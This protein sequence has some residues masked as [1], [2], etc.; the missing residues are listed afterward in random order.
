MKKTSRQD[1]AKELYWRTLVARFAESGLTQAAFCKQEGLHAG[2]FSSWKRAIAA[3]EAE[4]VNAEL[5]F[6]RKHTDEPKETYWRKTVSR[7]KHSGLSKDEFCEK[8]GIKRQ[9]F[10]YWRAELERRDGAKLRAIAQP[11]ASSASRFLPVQVAQ[12]EPFRPVAKSPQAIAEIDILCGTVRI[13]DTATT[14]A[15]TA[16]FKALK[17]STE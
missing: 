8:E 6:R 5:S 16:L 4:A 15:L 3:R 11:L 10:C 2:S 17:E 12:P 13:F 9:A 14:E 7:F 1:N